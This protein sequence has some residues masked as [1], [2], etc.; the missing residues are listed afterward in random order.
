VTGVIF[1]FDNAFYY[2]AFF[3]ICDLS[4]LFC[5]NTDCFP[6]YIHLWLFWR[7]I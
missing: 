6:M 7:Q 1:I 3:A 4:T 5:R 2:S